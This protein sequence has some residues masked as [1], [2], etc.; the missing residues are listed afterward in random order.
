MKF[1][2]TLS[3][4]FSTFQSFGCDCDVRNRISQPS[5]FHGD[6]FNGEGRT[7][8]IGFIYLK[9]K[10]RYFKFVA[11]TNRINCSDLELPY[12]DDLPNNFLRPTYMLFRIATA[13]N[14]FEEAMRLDHIKNVDIITRQKSLLRFVP[15]FGCTCPETY[16]ESIKWDLYESNKY[17]ETLIPDLKN[18]GCENSLRLLPSRTERNISGKLQEI[19]SKLYIVNEDKKIEIVKGYECNPM[20]KTA[21]DNDDT[22]NIT[23]EV[24]NN[25]IND[26]NMCKA[27]FNIWTS[28]F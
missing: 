2:I 26:L 3:L 19:N 11:C 27:N 28:T 15:Q 18:C 10:K 16:F 8:G 24:K 20:L 1:L 9:N 6:V 5:D 21:R 14:T 25:S 17:K 4:I 22:I 13:Y 7:S 23:S 12:V